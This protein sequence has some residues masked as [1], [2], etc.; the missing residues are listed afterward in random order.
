MLV[1][2]DILDV[3]NN[4][5]ESK[6][7][8]Q[9]MSATNTNSKKPDDESSS[10][11]GSKDTETIHPLHLVDNQLQYS[12]FNLNGSSSTSIA[13]ERRFF[14]THSYI[15]E[16]DSDDYRKYDDE[17]IRMKALALVEEKK[18]RLRLSRHSMVMFTSTKLRFCDKLFYLECFY[19]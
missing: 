7:P 15:G 2:T 18:Q 17:Y 8:Q 12:A 11:N 10:S 13:A 1:P 14:S 16:N 3:E 4:G 6:Y 9:E 19:V 5:T